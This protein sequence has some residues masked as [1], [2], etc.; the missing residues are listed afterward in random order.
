MAKPPRRREQAMP[1]RFLLVLTS[2]ET[3]ATWYPDPQCFAS[4]LLHMPRQT[5]ASGEEQRENRTSQDLRI[6]A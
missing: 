6:S 2:D 4:A 5:D 1:D 3:P